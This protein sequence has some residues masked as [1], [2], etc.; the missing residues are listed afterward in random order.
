M[1]CFTLFR[2]ESTLS[3][4]RLV[5]VAS[6]AG[7]C[8]AAVLATVNHAAEQAANNAVAVHYLLQFLLVVAI[9]VV[10]QRYVMTTS[11]DE[12]ERVLH[13]V[14]V[15]IANK[16]RHAELM[17]FE[18]IGRSE[19]YASVNRDTS[20]ISQASLVLID[21]A[22]SAFL[23]TF[24][25]LYILYLSGTAF[26][27]TV[28]FVWLALSIYFKRRL[29]L[30]QAIHTAN[31]RENQLWDVITGLLDGFKMVRLHRQRS[32]ELFTHAD[33][34]S[35]E[36]MTLKIGVR[37]LVAGQFIFAQVAFF[38][39]L[40]TMAFV[41]PRF[42]SEAYGDV[43][44][45]TTTAILFLIGPVGSLVN[46]IPTLAEAN[47]AAE[48]I[49]ALEAKLD[50]GSYRQTAD[51]T[52]STA[53]STL[54]LQGA[55]FTY[56][57]AG[58]EPPFSVGPIDVEVRCGEVVFVSGGNGAGKSTM[59]KLLTGLYRPSQGQVLV[60]GVAVPAEGREAYHERFAVVFSD[61]HLFRR[62][63]GIRGA[64]PD[65]IAELLQLL[66][67]DDKT[68]VTGDQFDTLDL[69]SGQRKRLALLVSLLEDRPVLV[70]D[71]WAADQDPHF[72][73]KFYE[74]IVPGLRAQGKT[75]IAVTHDDRYYGVADRLLEIC[76]GQLTERSQT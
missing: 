25:A 51:G 75:V 55:T 45:K 62:L 47:D 15:R 30:R 63:Y 41:V 37:H 39:L 31:D 42:G 33:D 24:T 14:R 26:V 61:F 11:A 10:A 72:R 66:E 13:Q 8:N 21:G 12:I 9:W 49:E 69:S 68:G 3:I 16:V 54:A 4:P 46:A 20:T 28:V 6:L 74:E 57:T 38:L 60:N 73:R 56:P 22:Q 36:A 71:E 7:L 19:I 70:F 1:K 52:A 59:L 34:L 67:V 44:I 17:T 40:G 65:R 32:E 64:T 27:L 23:V 35:H 43:V 5:G 48:G 29:P 18:R 53:F 2:Q 58:G 50:A 76:E